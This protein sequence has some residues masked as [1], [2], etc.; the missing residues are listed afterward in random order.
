MADTVYVDGSTLLTA[1]TM[2]DVN[3]LQYTIL[4]DPADAAAVKAALDLDTSD[5]VSFA[6]IT[7]TGL[8]KSSSATAGIGYATGAGGT[9]TQDTSIT[10]AVTI[11]KICG[12]IITFSTAL[13]AGVHYS[14]LVNNSAFGVTDTVS[15]SMSYA[16]G[17]AAVI[18]TATLVAAGSFYVT[19]YCTLA[20]TVSYNLNFTIHKSVII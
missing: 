18:P 15:F 10:T 7:S 3:R 5:S 20:G 17:G 9:V 13:S 12:E 19:L 8:I 14:F 6:A 16:S 11:N 1:D 4:G 2:N